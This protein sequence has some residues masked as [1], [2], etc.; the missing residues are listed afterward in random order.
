MTNSTDRLFLFSF[1]SLLIRFSFFL[2]MKM[3]KEL[4]ASLS[5]D[6]C[7]RSHHH[8]SCRNTSITSLQAKKLKRQFPLSEAD[9]AVTSPLSSHTHTHTLLFHKALGSSLI[10]HEFKMISE[11]SF[12]S[13]QTVNTD[14]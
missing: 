14:Q 6:C 13:L 12:F 1:L 11:S 3:L 8:A 5:D 9:L 10:L 4:R 2:V 7:Q